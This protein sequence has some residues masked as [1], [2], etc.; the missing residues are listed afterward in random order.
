MDSV[1]G[2]SLLLLLKNIANSSAIEWRKDNRSVAGF[3]QEA[4]YYNENYK[5]RASMFANGTLRLDKTQNTDSGSYSVIVFDKSGK[6]TQKGIAQ[7]IIIGRLSFII[8][9]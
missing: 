1:L 4:P 5:D 7:I 3:K 2:S 6:N 8:C 9:M